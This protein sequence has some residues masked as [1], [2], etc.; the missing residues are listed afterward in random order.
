MIGLNGG[1][2][3]AAR[4]QEQG[5]AVINFPVGDVRPEGN[6]A[7]GVFTAFTPYACVVQS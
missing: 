2:L 5:V 3:N 6:R 4:L 1:S 7:A